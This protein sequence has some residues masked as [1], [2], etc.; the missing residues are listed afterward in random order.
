MLSP[1]S[2]GKLFAR[3]LIAPIRSA[4]RSND[5]PINAEK[6][7]QFGFSVAY[8]MCYDELSNRFFALCIKLLIIGPSQLRMRSEPE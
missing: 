3:K 4:N 8:S 5:L 6:Q 1:H 2:A 7:P